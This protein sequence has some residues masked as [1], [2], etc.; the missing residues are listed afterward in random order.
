L[1][2]TNR[3]SQVDDRLHTVEGLVGGLGITNVTRDQSR[4][5]GEPGLDP[6]VDLLLESVEDH[7][8][9]TPADKAGREMSPDKACPSGHK[10]S[11]HGVN[12]ADATAHAQSLRRT[13]EDVL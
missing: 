11:R 4:A 10:H 8:L 12:L 1:A 13:R 7:H 3:G 6:G 9:I 5:F 2:D